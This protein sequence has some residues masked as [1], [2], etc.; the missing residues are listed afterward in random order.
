VNGQNFAGGQKVI[1]MKV[2]NNNKKEKQT[3]PDGHPC[4]IPSCFL[5]AFIPFAMDFFPYF[6]SVS[7]PPN[8]INLRFFKS[9]SA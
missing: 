9:N 1:K 5:A 7:F 2:N 4:R 8:G 6:S 3:V